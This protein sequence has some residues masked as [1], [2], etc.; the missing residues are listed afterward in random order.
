MKRIYTKQVSQKEYI[1]F[2]GMIAGCVATV[3]MTLFLLGAHRFLPRWQRYALPP[4]EVTKEL[5]QRVH[6]E[7]YLD[8][9]RLLASSLVFHFGYGATMGG[10]YGPLSELIRLPA[11][12]KGALFGIA[13]WAA[14]YLGWMPLARIS[15]EAPHEPL[16]RNLMMIIAHIIWGSVTGILAKRLHR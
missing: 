4:E 16:Q 1:S 7:R 9:P 3:P 11:F 2:A 5:A 15:V 12:L 13:I 10:L 6:L 8:K 14:S